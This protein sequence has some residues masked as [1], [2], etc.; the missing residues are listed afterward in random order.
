METGAGAGTGKFQ[1]GVCCR[2]TWHLWTP[3]FTRAGDRIQT[4]G[5]AAGCDEG[6]RVATVCSHG[7][8]TAEDAC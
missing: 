2:L 4:V 7:K 5:N 3:G 8:R 1:R 6:G